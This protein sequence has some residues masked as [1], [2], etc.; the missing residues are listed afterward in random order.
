[1]SPPSSDAFD[2]S[3]VESDQLWQSDIHRDGRGRPRSQYKVEQIPFDFSVPLAAPP[4][5]AE[6]EL[7]VADRVR[8]AATDYQLQMQAYALA[9][10][11]LMPSLVKS[12]SSIISTLH[13]LD[14]NR[15]FHL[16]G[17]LLNHETCMLAIDDAMMQ[18]ISS[19][20]PSQFP[21]RPAPHCR[22]CNFLG[23]CPAGRD[24]LR[25]TRRDSAAADLSRVAETFG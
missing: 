19:G 4:N 2:Q 15:E 6:P 18:I 3:R 23:I 8:I 21:V 25:L 24:W 20:E 17:D 9:V 11:E 1:P 13:F 14:P 5:V 16:A 10:I 22:M 7:S 12:G